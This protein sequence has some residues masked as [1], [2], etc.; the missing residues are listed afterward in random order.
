MAYKIMYYPAVSE[1][2]EWYRNLKCS[3]SKPRVGF[4]VQIPDKYIKANNLQAS[5]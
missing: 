1:L 3:V 4:K 2:M 5:V